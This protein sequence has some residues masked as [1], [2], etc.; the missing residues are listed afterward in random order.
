VSEKYV[1]MFVCT[2]NTCRSA[3]AEGALRTLLEKERPGKF[4]VIS[5]GTGAASGFPA[6]M[7]AVEA[8][9]IW[10]CD[11][12]RHKSRPLTPELID[13]SDL[14]LA[15]TPSHYKQVLKLRP[16]ARGRTYLVEKFPEPGGEGQGIDDPIGQTLD[17][18][19]E[20]FLTIG[21]Y[22]GQYVQEI[23][24]RIDEKVDAS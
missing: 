15:L 16:D 4:E 3:M 11:I 13:R 6:T 18:Y 20:T 7:Y 12:S 17:R 22:L 10:A 23:V 5:S 19:N 21:E 8:A 24:K 14:I 1:I 2:G 9:K